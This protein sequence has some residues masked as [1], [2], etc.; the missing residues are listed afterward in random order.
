VW[1]TPKAFLQSSTCRPHL[2]GLC[3][4]DDLAS[5]LRTSQPSAVDGVGVQSITTRRGQPPAT[6]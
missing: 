6:R 3:G 2:N 4:W 1:R 5:S